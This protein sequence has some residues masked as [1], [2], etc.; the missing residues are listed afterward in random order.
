LRNS[1]L[2]SSRNGISLEPDLWGTDATK[3]GFFLAMDP[4]EHGRLR[5]LVGNVFKPGWVQGMETRVRELTLARLEPVLDEATFDFAE[6]AGGLPNDVIC[7]IVGIPAAD[8]DMIRAENDLLNHCENAVDT[9]SNTA[10][11]AGF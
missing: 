7:E 4:P 3:T 11:D 2:F 1:A 9:R 10:I 8:R 6:F 5:R